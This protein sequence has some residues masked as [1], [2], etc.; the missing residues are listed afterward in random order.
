MSARTS[1]VLGGSSGIGAA[2]VR[3]LARD[4]HDVAVCHLSGDDRAAALVEEV[5]AIGRTAVAVRADVRTEDGAHR[6]CA[7]SASRT[8]S[9]TSSRSSPAT[10]LAG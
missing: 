8:T 1:L 10:R 6:R 3:A 5:A 4:G 9:P 7:A 2:V